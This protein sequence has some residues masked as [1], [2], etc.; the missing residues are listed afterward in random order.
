MFW[1]SRFSI[2]PKAEPGG[3]PGAK[4]M[5]TLKFEYANLVPPFFDMWAGIW[6]KLC[7]ITSPINTPNQRIVDA[8][9]AKKKQ[10]P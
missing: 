3:Y 8:L 2:T 10:F 6:L 7:G 5:Q 1:W 9:V 4:K